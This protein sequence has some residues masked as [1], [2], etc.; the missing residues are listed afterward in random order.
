MT[1]PETPIGPRRSWSRDYGIRLFFT[2]LVV[3]LIV[4]FGSQLLWFGIDYNLVSLPDNSQLRGLALTYTVVSVLLALIWMAMLVLYGTHLQRVTG[5]GVSEYKLVTD[6]SIRLFGVLAIVAFVFKVDLARGYILTALP[7]GVLLLLVGR[8]AWRQWLVRRRRAGR[9]SARTLVVGSAGGIRPIT[10]QFSQRF[11]YAG[12]QIIG[13]CLTRGRETSFGAEAPVLGGL[14]EILDLVERYRIDVVLLTG[15]DDLTPA[16]VRRISW[17]LEQTS[18]DLAVS[19]S[20]LEVV[21]P[22]IHSRSVAG[23]PIIHVDVPQYE[24]R[25]AVL[26]TLFDKAAAALALIVLAIPMLLLAMA[27]RL[28]SEG[29]V[30]FRQERI[31]LQGRPFKMLKFRSM[32]VDAEQQLAVLKSRNESEGGV[33]FK[34]RD[35][36]RVTPIGRFMRRHSLDELPQFFNVLVGDMSLVG[37]RPP[38]PSEVEKYEDHVQRRFLVKPGLTGPWQVSG[39]ADLTWDEGVRLDLHYV[40]NWSLT[41]DLI[42]LWRT[43]KVV[44]GAEGG[45]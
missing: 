21:G 9:Y 25:K 37:P 29:P 41:G 10:E 26:K 13:V 30:F 33:L 28:S 17:E 18:V 40:E 36:P 23:M 19:P 12:Y 16:V 44:F 39:R 7:T 6:A 3:I 27:V 15:S 11:P 20:L 31:G 38:L 8:W 4:V 34:I 5:I 24:G 42:Y 43:V 22:R 1:A 45:Y 14:D 35:D 32:V 2:D